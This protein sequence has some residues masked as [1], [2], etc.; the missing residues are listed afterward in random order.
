MNINK[1]IV[2]STIA[3]SIMA[4]SSS[5]FFANADEISD[6]Q[7]IE[8]N[9]ENS[10]ENGK[11]K[12]EENV[13]EENIVE[14]TIENPSKDYKIGES[15]ISK[16]GGVDRYDTAIKI[17]QNGWKNGSDEVIIVNGNAVADS[18]SVAPL[19][20]KLNAPILLTRSNELNITVEAELNRL[21]AKKVTIIGGE[22]S[23]SN[24]VEMKLKELGFETERISG[25]DRIETSIKVAQKLNEN[26]IYGIETAFIVNGFKGLPDA[27]GIGSIAAQKNAP[28]IYTKDNNTESVENIVD[29]IGIQSIY[30]IGG[31]SSLNKTFD[32][33]FNNSIR[34]SGENRHDTNTK[35]INHFY[36]NGFNAVYVVDDGSKEPSKLID[37]VLINSAII[38]SSDDNNVKKG[39][40]ILTSR[41]HGFD[42]GQLKLMAN[43]EALLSNFV[44]V[45]GGDEFFTF[46]K[47]AVDF[48]NNKSN[49]KAIGALE[50]ILA[51]ENQTLTY[52]LQENEYK[53]TG[54]N[55]LEM[56]NC[57]E[58]TD[59]DISLKQ[60]MLSELVA[61]IKIKD[62]VKAKY[63]SFAYWT[64]SNV[65][66]SKLNTSGI[67][68]T[69]VEKQYINDL[70]NQGDI[71]KTRV[72]EYIQSNK[73]KGATN[74]GNR[75]IEIDISSQHMWLKD[76]DKI[77][78]STPIV[79]GNPNQGMATPIGIFNMSYRSR[80]VV[81]RGPGYASPV[82]YWMPFNGS[83]GIHDAYWQ[84]FFG[85][86]RYTYAG[87]HGCINTPLSQVSQI[88]KFSYSGIPVIVH[89]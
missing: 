23:V 52:E 57:N 43:Q 30:I 24:D 25:V 53:V 54:K 2:C 13:S 11:P 4:T 20:S 56:I 48:N 31:E 74:I 81:L 72:P 83:I 79:S 45:S 21:N 19:A 8:T 16:W 76:H 17:S 44:Q 62:S 75:Y 88:Y 22:G 64:S 86:N 50:K 77:W 37:S 41:N 38:A 36:K 71:N 18:L 65:E 60:N 46:I 85:G 32:E 1:K 68:N 33:T 39:P 63:A 70:V 10:E 89:Y 82:K 7:N 34:I 42:F 51:F 67:L 87:S 26:Q 47:T 58:E 66:I 27:A 78:V 9:N 59:F 35:I 40:V 61:K 14:P 69:N 55:I 84:P 49:P 29:E 28:I 12:N 3:V 6:T 15:T 73:P 80:D 5:L